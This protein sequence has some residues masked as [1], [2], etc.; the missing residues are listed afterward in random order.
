M[1][2]SEDSINFKI[3][4]PCLI[5]KYTDTDKAP[6]VRI[7]PV[8]SMISKVVTARCLQIFHGNT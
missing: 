5:L 4:I 7:N 8:V 2:C 6:A 1:V 3:R